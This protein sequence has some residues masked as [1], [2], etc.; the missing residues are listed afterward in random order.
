MIQGL[1]YIATLIRQ[2]K[3]WESLYVDMQPDYQL[4]TNPQFEDAVIK[5]YTH[6]LEYE[7]RFFRHLTRNPV[8]RGARNMGKLDD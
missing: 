2:Y 6:I 8:H 3:I 5:L 1:E 7:A 4:Q